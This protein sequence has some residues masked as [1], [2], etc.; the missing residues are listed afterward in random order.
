MADADAHRHEDE[1]EL[2]DLRHR[3]ASEKA[4]ASAVAH[5]GHNEEHNERIAD[6]HEQ[7]KHERCVAAF[8]QIGEIEARAE[9]NEEEQQ[10]EVAQRRQPREDGLA[11][12]RRGES[13]SGHQAAQLLAESE[14]V[15]HRC[16]ARRQRHRKADQQFRRL[17]Q[18]LG[19]RVGDEAHE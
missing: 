11:V 10:Q 7:R 13:H 16:E 15:A 19:Q 3:Q 18:L 6:Q 1:R 8:A 12:G 9:R 5:P 2:A 14:C 4:G 17:R